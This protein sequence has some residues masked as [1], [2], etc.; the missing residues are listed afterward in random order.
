MLQWP[1]GD[2]APKYNTPRDVPVQDYDSARP[3]A[4]LHVRTCA[5]S[6]FCR[7]GSRG[8]LIGGMGY[9]LGRGYMLG[10]AGTCWEEVYAGEGKGVAPVCNPVVVSQEGALACVHHRHSS[11][12]CS[13]PSSSTSRPSCTCLIPTPSL[14]STPSSCAQTPSQQC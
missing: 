5:N 6:F 2:K 4:R 12:D 11:K 7:L 1:K 13:V 8:G 10:C 3:F 9:V 14:I